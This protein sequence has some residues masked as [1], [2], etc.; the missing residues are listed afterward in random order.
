LVAIPVGRLAG[1]V[2]KVPTSVRAPPAST[3]RTVMLEL[4]WLETNRRLSSGLS[5]TTFEFDPASGKKNGDPG[6]ELSVCAWATVADT[7]KKHTSNQRIRQ[8]LFITAA[9]VLEARERFMI[10]LL[11]RATAHPLTRVG[12]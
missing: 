11:F 1:T 10:F 4:D 6:I 12:L 3:F 8:L 2:G 5:S 9:S 7:S